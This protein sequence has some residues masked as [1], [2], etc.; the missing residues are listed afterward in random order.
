MRKLW[1]VLVAAAVYACGQNSGDFVTESGVKVSCLEK[2]DGEGPM[3]DSIVV[4]KMKIETE[5]GEV[6]TETT[7]GMPMGVSYDPEMKAG[8]L[9]DVL[10][11]M[12]VGD[13]VTFNTTVKNLFEETYHS[14]IPPNLDSA[15]TVIIHMKLDDQMSKDAYRA[16]IMEMRQK[17]MERQQAILEEKITTD[18]DSIDVFLSGKGIE[19][20]TTESGL[21]YIITEEGSGPSV[22]PG[23]KVTVNYDGRLLFTDEQFDSNQDGGFSFPIGQGRVIKGWDEGI[24]YLKEGGKATL[25]IPSPLAYGPRPMGAVIQPY[26]ILVF[27]VEL[28][29]VEKPETK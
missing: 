10:N 18:G 19:A 9:Q 29:K 21:R 8:D 22:E 17:E 12:V 7:A 28:V 24:A 6:L 4:L 23:D 26:S 2:G 20:I 25:Y 13:S 11:K 1:V 15:G 16:F 5:D 14:P 27:D 3:K